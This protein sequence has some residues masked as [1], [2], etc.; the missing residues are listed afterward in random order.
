MNLDDERLE[1]EKQVK[2]QLGRKAQAGGGAAVLL[3]LLML[4]ALPPARPG[5]NV[6]LHPMAKLMVGIGAFS[7]A[8]GTLGRIFFLPP[9]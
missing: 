8:I 2:N 9:E 7:A 5:A 6:D 4:F 3:G 1:Y